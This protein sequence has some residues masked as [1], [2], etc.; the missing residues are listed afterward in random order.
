MHPTH[1]T[2][3]VMGFLAQ[4]LGWVLLP[5]RWRPAVGPAL[6]V[7]DLVWALWFWRD[8]RGLSVAGLWSLSPVATWL[9]LHLLVGPVILVALVARVLPRWRR[10]TCWTGFALI[11]AAYA[12]GLGEAYGPPVVQEASLSFPDLPP[13][14]EGYRIV[15]IGDL[16]AG[17]FAGTR[18]MARWARAVQAAHGDLVVGAGDFITH[19]P[20]EAERP[21]VAFQSVQPTDGKVGVTGNHDE[22]P[23]GLETAQRLRRHG[24]I[25]LLDEARVL[26]R[27][28]QNLILLGVRYPITPSLVQ[29]SQA[30]WGAC[31]LPEG[32][33]IGLAHSPEQWPFLVKQGARLTLAAHTHGG[34][35]NLSP[36]LN[37]AEDFTPYIHGL[38]RSGPQVL[39]VTR[40]LGLTSLPFR[41]RCRP[42]IAV[43][44]LHRG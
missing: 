36:F 25:M 1:A 30:A 35:V 10:R 41:I 37:L 13:A 44:T 31:T 34:Q 4:L 38:Y 11:L 24:W 9:T 18:T 40:G 6:L 28:D 19:L 23:P 5:R 32:F 22:Y 21:G 42:E 39:W 2:L 17:P 27:G 43:L 7:L 14:F 8:P 16:H 12:W 15:L 20:E 29:A 26:R 3:I 33:R